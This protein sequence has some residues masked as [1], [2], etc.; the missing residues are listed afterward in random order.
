MSKSNNEDTKNSEVVPEE[1]AKV[2]YDLTN[3]IL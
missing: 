3:D 1:F 2:V